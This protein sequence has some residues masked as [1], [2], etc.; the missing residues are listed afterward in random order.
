MPWATA[1]TFG[2]GM[3]TITSLLGCDDGLAAEQAAKS[4]QE[5]CWDGGRRCGDIEF[6]GSVPVAC[7]LTPI[8]DPEAACPDTRSWCGLAVDECVRR[9]EAEF[10]VDLGD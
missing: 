1:R 4:C 3:I 9:C 10:G 7:T 2:I 8:S 5:A 6:V